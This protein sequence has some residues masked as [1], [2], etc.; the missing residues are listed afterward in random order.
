MPE[1]IERSA[2]ARQ[3][4]H[5]HEEDSPGRMVFRPSEFEFPPSRGRRSLDLS[6]DG[7]VSLGLPGPDDRPTSTPATWTLDGRRL[8]LR[9]TGVP[10]ERFDIEELSPDRLIL[11]PSG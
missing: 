2:L 6:A 9:R 8:T 1:P 10:D 11:R 4:T 5:S 3:W 7:E